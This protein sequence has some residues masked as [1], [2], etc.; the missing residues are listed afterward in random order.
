MFKKIDITI[1]GEDL[2][3]KPDTRIVDLLPK[4]PHKG[5]YPAVGAILNN[6]LVEFSYKL[7]SP[8]EINTVDL[9]VRE[10]MDIYRRTTLMILYSALAEIAPQA[11]IVVGQSI[12]VGYFFEVHNHI[13][14]QKFISSLDEHMR[15]IVEKDVPLKR[16]WVSVEEAMEV[17]QKQGSTD[18][19]KLLN[20]LRRAEVPIVRLGK[21]SGYGFGPI[22]YRTGLIDKF[23][24]RPYE[25]GIV[26]GFPNENNEL[27]EETKTQPKLFATYLETKRWNEL[28]HIE[29]V[30]DL[31]EKCMGRTAG[32]L[33]KVAEALH[34]KKIVTIADQIASSKDV[35]LVLIAGPS[36]SGKTTFSK[37]LS[38]HLKT[39][40]LEPIAISIDNYYVD[41]SRTP[42]H[43]DGTYDFE[44]I[45]ALD[46]DLFND[47]MQKLLHGEEVAIP[48]YSFPL[49]KRDVTKSRKLKLKKGQILITE[50]IHGLNE[51]MSSAIPAKNKFKI[52]VSALTQLCLDDHNRIFTNDTRL[53]RRI[54]R[55]RL[56]RGTVAAETI[57]GWSSVRAGEKKYIFPFQEDADVQFNSALAYE[58]S[59]LKP[60]SERYLAEVP[61]SHASFMESYRLAKFFSY[62]IPILAVEVPKSSI[63][64]EFIGGSA[65]NYS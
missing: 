60:Y 63:L 34:E 5:S 14:D 44:S 50:G 28:V 35:R 15:R 25:H 26:L 53:C 54:V 12:G 47:H 9:S 16:E 55:D 33:V 17:F 56:F 37:R 27:E 57:E 65:F 21:Y 22:A 48:F 61:R 31:N 52:F 13:V 30:A 19:S 32:D 8:G 24:I 36:S 62:F 3:V 64:R 2:S 49:G 6:H 11:R 38:I 46:I 29:N 42:K 51:I 58:H 20:Q 10:G 18:K 23:S 1:N 7:T 59:L 45:D 40:G 39:Y 4:A 43:A 41:R